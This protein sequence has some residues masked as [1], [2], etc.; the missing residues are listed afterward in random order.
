MSQFQWQVG[1]NVALIKLLQITPARMQFFYFQGFLC[2][3]KK[4][5]RK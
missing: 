5:V 4:N 3:T 1:V 2:S